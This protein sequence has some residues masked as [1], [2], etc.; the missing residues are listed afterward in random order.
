MA[1]QKL[2]AVR[3]FCGHH[4]ISADFIFSLQQFELVELVTVKRT[5]Y[6]PEKNLADVERMIRLRNELDIN[7]EGIHAIQ[8]LCAVLEQKEK[9]LNRLRNLL[10]FYNSAG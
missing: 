5:S 6:I 3:E 4:N 1:A 9:E 10:D 8:K 2:I 7:I